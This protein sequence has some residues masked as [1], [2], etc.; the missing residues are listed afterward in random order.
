MPAILLF[1]KDALQLRAATFKESMTQALGLSCYPCRE[2]GAQ[3]D[4]F[5]PAEDNVQSTRVYV[6]LPDLEGDE[7]TPEV[8]IEIAPRLDRDES[9][10]QMIDEILEQES[11][12]KEDLQ[13]NSYDIILTFDDTPAGVEAGSAVAYVLASETGSGVLIPAFS[14]E[15]DTV[16][17]QDAEDFAD[18]VFGEEDEDD[19]DDEDEDDEELEEEEEDEKPSR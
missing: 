13:D 1:A 3:T 17:F 7:G 18:A 2:G 11:S 6:E 9:I 10:Q 8:G 19:E 14:E 15:D 12:L 16:W 4:E 5:E